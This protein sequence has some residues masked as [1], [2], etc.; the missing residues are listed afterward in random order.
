MIMR[1]LRKTFALLL[2]VSVFGIFS[3]CQKW[4]DLTPTNELTSESIYKDANGYYQVIAK[5][6]GTLATTGNNGPAGSPDINTTI[7]D[8]GFSDFN[9]CFW[10]LQELPTEEAVWSYYD[11]GTT[12]LNTMEWTANN[13][14]V[15]GMFKRTYFNLV[16]CNEFIEQA[17]DAKLS[18]RGIGGA[19]LAK[20]KEF[21]EEARFLRAFYYWV[22]VDLYGKGPFVTSI[23][24]IPPPVQSRAF[25]F[26]FIQ[27]ELL[28]L[29][30]KLAAPRQNEYG[31]VDRASAWALLARLYLNADVYLKDVPHD[32]LFPKAAE[33]AQKVIDAG[34]DLHD[35]YEELF[36]ANN[37]LR[38]NELIFAIPYDG[39]NTQGYGGANTLINGAIFPG[40]GMKSAHFGVNGGWNCLRTRKNLPMLF[41]D[42]G[43]GERPDKRALFHREGAP[44]D[45]VAMLASSEG[46]KVS[47]FRNLSLIP[48]G[49]P[50]S[51]EYAGDSASIIF[52]ARQLSPGDVINIRGAK[53]DVL[54][55]FFTITK[56]LESTK[57]QV[58]I[59]NPRNLTGTAEANG[60]LSLTQAGRDVTG[61]F[62]D[63]DYPLFRLAEMYLIYAEASINGGG[64]P[65]IGVTYINKLRRRAYGDE[66]GNITT[67]DLTMDFILAERGR[68]L[69]W[70]GH[71]RT[72]LIRHR[73]FSDG[74]FLWPY[75][76]GAERGRAVSSHLEIYPIPAVDITANPNLTQNPGY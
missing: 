49:N 29:E 67:G 46:Y 9:R 72:D 21:R 33:Y 70:E 45:I 41:V 48:G 19:D 61:Q 32:N 25:L 51:I 11:N 38:R 4:L 15:K 28:D 75:K 35:N 42:S 73:K 24:S 60:F 23:T 52:S 58:R 13:V 64:D 43:F 6:Y 12:D 65:G 53:P 31:R 36:M 50:S 44:I 69:Y 18:E 34:Y 22:I 27:S 14:V 7:I 40:L 63:V 16:M 3:S 30:S 10:Y 47:K 8:E 37:H 74:S 17:S 71:R 62:V 5:V 55:G 66:S 26:N 2:S 59:L 20:I 54:N 57:Y 76:G 1:Y 39:V 56:V 68:E